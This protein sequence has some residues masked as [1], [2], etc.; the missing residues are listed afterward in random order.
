MNKSSVEEQ[1]I[2]RRTMPPLEGGDVMCDIPYCERKEHEC[3]SFDNRNVRCWTCKKFSCSRCVN[4]IW[5]G[6]WK[7]DE[8]Y[9]KPKCWI[10]GLEHQK[11]SCPYCR[12]GFDR[13]VPI[14]GAVVNVPSPFAEDELMGLT[15]SESDS[16]SESS[17]NDEE[18]SADTPGYAEGYE[19]FFAML[20]EEAD[21]QSSSSDE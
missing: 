7:K 11:F 21:N 19:E 14:E 13:F 10:P 2:V 20:D 18:E 17:S 6:K 16:N 3:M 15:P 4:L 8:D 1:N 12:S 9:P 5:T